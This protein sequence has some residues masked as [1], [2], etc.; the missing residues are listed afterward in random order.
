MNSL[1]SSVPIHVVS[2]LVSERQFQ[3]P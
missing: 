3:G 2:S 1:D